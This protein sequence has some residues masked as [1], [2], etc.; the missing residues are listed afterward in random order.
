MNKKYTLENVGIGTELAKRFT[1]DG[2]ILKKECSCGELL[3]VDLGGDY[4]SYPRV[5]LPED[6]Y[7]YC[8]E[9]GTDYE[10]AFRVTIHINLEVEE[11]LATKKIVSVLQG[12]SGT[13]VMELL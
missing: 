9:C 10:E 1:L 6:I 5:G 12:V 7:L 3:T 8:D 4:L 11:L 2:A 13:V